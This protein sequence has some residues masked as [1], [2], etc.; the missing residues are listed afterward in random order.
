M[1]APVRRLVLTLALSASAACLAAP[2]P[3]PAQDTL[4]EQAVQALTDGRADEASQILNRFLE[5]EPQHAGAWLDLAISQCELGHAAEAERLFAAIEARFAPPP[6][7]REIIRIQ[8]EHGC[9]PPAA[10]GRLALTL[11]YGYDDNI[12]Q[13][14]SNSSFILGSGTNAKVREL[15][16]DYLPEADRYSSGALEYTYAPRNSGW[17]GFAQLL[18]RK[19]ERI[20]AQDT[21]SALL[22]AERGWRAGD[23]RGM[24]TTA[25]SL[26]QLNGKLYQRQVQLQARA[27]PPVSLPAPLEW[28][29]LGG[30]SHV[31]FPTRTHYDG[32]T[33]E[34]GSHLAY[35]RGAQ[36]GQVALGWLHDQGENNRLGGNRN[37]WYSNLS[38]TWQMAA[39]WRTE[40]GWTRQDW[41]SDEVYAPNLIDIRRR[42]STRQLR[43]ATEWVLQPNQSLRLEL[44]Q[45][46][47]QE[48]ISI[49]QY[50]SRAIQLS[51]R[52]TLP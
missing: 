39:S 29:L 52:W 23:W 33:T 44:R 51:W 19:H 32:T 25:F 27:T 45:V 5:R 15:T 11:G 10:Q 34:L 13:G 26:L 40:A 35:Q 30:L 28:S 20:H 48:N 50:D 6:G 42:Q 9:R 31:N 1:S 4:Y 8:R 21:A 12:N 3:E 17:L 49:F 38:W 14:A 22:G 37:G 16:S 36:R 7:I 2:D 43:L 47:N 46:K 24:L 18:N 41:N